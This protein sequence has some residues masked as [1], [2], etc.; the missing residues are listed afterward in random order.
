MQENKW[1]K[2][3]PEIPENV[4]KAVLGALDMIEKENSVVRKGIVKNMENCEATSKKYTVKKML[5]PMAAVA[6]CAALL[7]TAT[8]LNGKLGINNPNE[9]H[10]SQKDLT[11]SN[12]AEVLPDFY[13]TAYAAEL[14]RVEINEENILFADIGLGEAGYTGMLFRIQGEDVS[15]VKISLDKG[16][17]Y[18]ATIENTTED[19]L[20]DW[21]AHGSPDED[22]NPD[23]HTIIKFTPQ[24]L[25]GENA[26]SESVQLYHCT[27]KGSEISERYNDEMYYGFY[28]PD[29]SLS[30]VSSDKDLASAYQ[31]L[32]SVFEDSE[33]KVTVTHNNGS[34]S[35]KVYI[36]SVEKLVQD[37]N[38]VVTQEVWSG[39]SEGTFVYGI[40][41]KEK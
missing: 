35:E 37:E 12:I 18:S 2:E 23:T 11:L 6:A 33:L 19:A 41:A 32:L 17:L 25:E 27:K 29:N 1:E 34:I 8:T 15:D 4:H 36:L 28:I 20:E 26:K 21:L 5:R 24:D 7:V 38:G 22:N 10:I 16:E 13:I 30:S 3:M 39:D 31:N 9:N 14:D 40:L